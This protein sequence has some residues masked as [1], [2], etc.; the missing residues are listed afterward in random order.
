MNDQDLADAS[1]RV[2]T[3]DDISESRPTPLPRM[4]ND[5]PI[6]HKDGALSGFLR[7]LTEA[8]LGRCLVTGKL[9]CLV[10]DCPKDYAVQSLETSEDRKR[11]HRHVAD[12]HILKK[13]C[14]VC[15]RKLVYQKAPC[16]C[17]STAEGP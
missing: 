15:K 17:L 3:R 7:S 6:D 13:K 4:E 12:T 14:A 2:E 1:A 16:P 11:Y 10:A 9:L 5:D 8:T